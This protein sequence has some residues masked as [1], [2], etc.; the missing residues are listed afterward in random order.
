[1]IKCE[2]SI[3]LKIKLNN[4]GFISDYNKVLLHYY[5]FKNCELNNDNLVENALVTND[6]GILKNRNT[7]LE[8]EDLISINDLFELS[9]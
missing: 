8:Y 7:I 1:M 9:S 5:E 3:K 2:N 4:K 6:I